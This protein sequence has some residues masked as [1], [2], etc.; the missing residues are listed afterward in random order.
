[1]TRLAS[2]LRE[3]DNL[4]TLELENTEPMLVD[5]PNLREALRTLRLTSL[6]NLTLLRAGPATHPLL[7][8][9]LSQLIYLRVQ[10]VFSSTQVSTD[11]SYLH[12]VPMLKRFADTLEE[13]DWETGD[14]LADESRLYVA[15]PKLRRL[16]IKCGDEGPLAVLPCIRALPDTTHLS[17]VGR[18][19]IDTLRP[20]VLE[21]TAPAHT[22]N[23][24][25][26]NVT[27]LQGS[28]QDLYEISESASHIPRL[29]LHQTD[30]TGRRWSLPRDVLAR[31][32]PSHLTYRT[33]GAQFLHE[34]RALCAIDAGK[35]ALTHLELDVG[36][37]ELDD[38]NIDF[39]RAKSTVRSS[40]SRGGANN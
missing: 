27:E 6:K 31:T 18:R 2:A 36:I 40:P 23:D 14:R 5:Y 29:V 1:M 4:E 19:A 10:W 20:F 39:G 13:L 11:P 3:T 28:V 21:R 12:P 25:W 32:R 38:L 7:E 9:L 22:G 30:H 17:I 24:I 8:A 37:M 26:T 16:A 33:W 34:V 15:Y 35:D